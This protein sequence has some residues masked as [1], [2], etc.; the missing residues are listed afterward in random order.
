M[1][2]NKNLTSTGLISEKRVWCTKQCCESHSWVLCAF[3]I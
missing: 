3:H 2:N 1:Q